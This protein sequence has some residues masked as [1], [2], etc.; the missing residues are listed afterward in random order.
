MTVCTRHLVRYLLGP[1]VFPTSLEA[2][3]STSVLAFLLVR[4]LRV[5]RRKKNKTIQWNGPGSVL[6]FPCRTHHARLFPTKHAFSY[7]YLTVGIPVGFEDNAGGMVSVEAKGEP[8]H[9]P[10]IGLALRRPKAWFSIDPS[11]YLERGKSGLGLRGKL[12]EYLRTQGADPASYPYA[13]LVTAARFLGYQFNPVSFWYLY[14]ADK[15]LAAM[16]LEVNNTSDERRMYFLTAGDNKVG[17]DDGRQQTEANQGK[18]SPQPSGYCRPAFTQSWPKDFHVSPFNSRK[19]SYMV[20][21]SDPLSPCT[22]DKGSIS[23]T[24][25]LL[26]SKGQPKIVSSLTAEGPPIDPCTMAAMQKLRFLA[27]WWHVG[28][29]TFPRILLEA[30]RLL[31]HHKLRVWPRPEPLNGTISRR[32]TWTE[33]Q[34]EPIFRRYLQHL[35]DQTPTP[36]SITY[37]APGGM[38]TT[39][40]QLMMLS[41]SARQLMMLQQQQQ[42]CSSHAN[43]ATEMESL[44]LKVLTPVFYIGFVRYT[45]IDTVDALL[46]ELDDDHTIWV[47]R[48]DLLARLAMNEPLGCSSKLKSLRSGYCWPGW[49]LIMRRAGMDIDRGG[50]GRGLSGM[51]A[52]VLECED[53][54]VRRV[55]RWCVL[56]VL[57]AE[58]LALQSWGWL[59]VKLV[60]VP[61]F[62]VW[63]MASF[64]LFVVAR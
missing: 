39:A 54:R 31:L 32:A 49:K 43:T 27:S 18:R 58:K 38:T 52:Y 47:S 50:K 51:D 33:R 21:A 23:V 34:L 29:L 17:Q 10:W 37:T 28:L 8:N 36:L 45:N 62:L 46:S 16:I 3:L 1:V 22:H 2:T 44:E 7:S 20:T 13:Y 6:L 9:S 40:S 63:G 25:T 41:P 19:G 5:T 26:S 4:L 59:I 55:Y 60:L 12:D 35:L 42:Q 56:R 61:V 48:R 15:R 53:E 14:D 64:L 24:I 57:L 11:D 30:A